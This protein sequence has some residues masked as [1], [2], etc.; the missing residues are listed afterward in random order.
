MED[1][2]S[3]RRTR[4]PAMA[5]GDETQTDWVGSKPLDSKVEVV[6]G[7]RDCEEAE[8]P[9]PA[10]DRKTRIEYPVN[11]CEIVDGYVD[12]DPAVEPRES[13]KTIQASETLGRANICVEPLI[14]Y[15]VEYLRNVGEWEI[16]DDRVD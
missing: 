7:G 13:G 9:S 11:G 14:E 3:V 2:E 8:A 4:S 12:R 10:S 1:A 15:P 5:K 6:I 16:V